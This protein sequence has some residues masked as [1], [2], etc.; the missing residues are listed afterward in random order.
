MVFAVAFVVGSMSSLF[1]S[2]LQAFMP[3][4]LTEE[5][6]VTANSR[7]QL[8]RT[9]AWTAG[10]A[11]G[12]VLIQ[13]LGAAV[14]FGVNAGTFVFSALMVSVVRVIAPRPPR[15]PSRFRAELAEG[16]RFLW[17]EPRLRWATLGAA[18]ANMIFAPLEITLALFGR[19]QLG[20]SEAGVG[21]LYALQALIGA[22]G[23]VMAPAVARRLRLGRTFV[24]GLVLMAGG[25]LAVSQSASFIAVLPIGVALVGVSWI[26]I[27]VSTLRQRLTP[28][29]LMGRVIAA[30]RTLSWAGIPVGA[31]VGG[32]IG[33]AVGL[34]DLYVGTS[35]LVLILAVV[36]VV[37]PLW[38]RPVAVAGETA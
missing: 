25:F 4:T 28:A 1:D 9:L 7:L 8:V 29:A 30:S 22:A 34:V 17:Q 35:V 13:F 14:A 6:L 32:L 15:P 20:L 26:N 19:E 12:G 3:L 23:A 10:A 5:L 37:T 16:L 24:V 21:W 31:A 2:G 11:A 27:S 38:H 18:A 36:L 33:E